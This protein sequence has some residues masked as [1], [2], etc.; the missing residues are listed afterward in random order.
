MAHE[1]QSNASRTNI[2]FCVLKKSSNIQESVIKLHIIKHL[3]KYECKFKPSDWM[4]SLNQ[5]ET[6]PQR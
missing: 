2:C 1:K 6:F 3:Q 4:Q 5:P